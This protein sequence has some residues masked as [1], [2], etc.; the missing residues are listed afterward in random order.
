MAFRVDISVNDRA[1]IKEI[2]KLSRKLDTKT[3]QGIFTKASKPFSEAMSSAAPRADRIVKRYSTAKV[4]K[5]R[6][7]P[8]GFGNVVAEYH[9]GNLGRSWG[10]LTFRG[11]RNMKAIFVGPKRRKTN[12]HGVFNG[13]R[14]D[15]YYAHLVPGLDKIVQ[16]A[17]NSTRGG[18]LQNIIIGLRNRVTR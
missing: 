17:W 10:R 13:R 18:V 7:A 14:A 3:V 5:S 2:T 8:K 16:S 6:R 9:P 4:D 15:G 1:A 11:S 12:T